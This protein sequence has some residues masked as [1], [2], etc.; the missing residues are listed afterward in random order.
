MNALLLALALAQAQPPTETAQPLPVRFWSFQD[1]GQTFERFQIQIRDKALDKPKVSPKGQ[2]KFPF[3]TAGYGQVSAT[4]EQFELRFRVYS[5]E[6]KVEADLAPLATRMLLRLWEY[7]IDRL[8]LDHSPAY[9]LQLVDVYL[10][11]EGEPG[12]EHL[13]GEDQT[14]LDEWGKPRKSNMIYIYDLETFVSLPEMAREVAHEYGHATLPPV[15]GFSSPEYW[16]NGELG[17]RLYLTWML[18]EL[19]K[20]TLKPID[21]MGA[22]MKGLETYAAVNVT[23][24]I[25]SVAVRGIDKEQWKPMN[26]A[27]MELYLGAMLLAERIFP[28]E[29]FRRGLLLGGQTVREAENGLARAAE[30]KAFALQNLG[31][32]VGKSIYIP[33]GDAKI[34]GAKVLGRKGI[35]TKI[36]VTSTKINLS[37]KTS[38]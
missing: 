34:T 17:E 7:N 33:S 28:V 36:Q 3:V 8:R 25:E 4:A 11:N 12:G 2:W 32:Y 26:R 14:N 30:E 35:W 38:K 24:L 31:P 13:F 9:F 10:C 22:D 29:V 21:C 23:P 1:I 19:K 37:P 20:G 15:G 6:R 27:T 5:Q 16:A 18:R